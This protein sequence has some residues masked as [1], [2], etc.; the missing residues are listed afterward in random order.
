MEMSKVLKGLGIFVLLILALCI[1][2][3]I[4][5]V[6]SSGATTNTQSNNAGSNTAITGGYESAT[7]YQSGSSSNST[8]SNETNNSSNTKTAVNSSS[9]PAMSVYGQDSCVIPLA[10]G[11]TV[12]GFSGTFGSYYADPNCERRKSVAVLSKLGMKVA[13]I[14]L[15]CQDE[16]VW[17]SMMNAGTP[18]PVDGLIGEQAK[19]RWIEKRKGELR[20]TGGKPTSMTWNE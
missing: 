18:C 14:S 15:M 7:T 6:T 9:A 8:T 17:Q 13:A 10:G 4:A 2:N 20:T 16:N 11:V 12:I 1:E 5:D 19:A 3:A